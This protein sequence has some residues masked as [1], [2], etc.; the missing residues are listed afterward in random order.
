MLA[1][2]PCCQGF[3]EKW[4]ATKSC[5]CMSRSWQRHDLWNVC[6]CVCAWER[7]CVYWW[8]MRSLWVCAGHVSAS[9]WTCLSSLNAYVSALMFVRLQTVYV[10]HKWWHLVSVFWSCFRWKAEI[11][12]VLNALACRRPSIIKY[13]CMI[14]YRQCLVSLCAL[15]PFRNIE[16]I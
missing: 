13:N 15:G 1:E 9:C 16:M 11:S 7:A 2:V 5:K 12:A 3:C 8:V 6:V 10:H 4:K 14:F